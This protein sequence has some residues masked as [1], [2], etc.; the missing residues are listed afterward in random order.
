[1]AAFDRIVFIGCGVMG[2]ALL[3][4]VQSHLGDRAELVIVEPNVERATFL[5][6]AYRVRVESLDAAVRE[7][8]TFIISVKPQQVPSLLE[9][10]SGCIPP[11]SIVISI[12]AGV[13]E[14]QFIDAFPG[15]DV[16]RVMPNTPAKIGHGVTGI[17]GESASA[18]A[19]RWAG[20]LFSSVGHV[21]TI[22]ES[23]MDALTAVSGSG[24][25]YVFLLAEAMID[26]AQALG[27]SADEARQLVVGTIVGAGALLTA[28]G[29]DPAELRRQVTSPGG[30]TQAAIERMQADGMPEAV[31]AGMRAARDR[32]VE[33]S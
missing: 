20:E 25:A 4:G 32:S 28:T 17:A 5:A 6:D 15:T 10:L 12:A 9:E 26:G 19:R 30:T 23:S 27:L 13:H 16:I 18:P 33:L 3:T 1:M 21:V 14:R 24:P 31:I 22:P 8:A 2:E 7:Q 29:E 11:G